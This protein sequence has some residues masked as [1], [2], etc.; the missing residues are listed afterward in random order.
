MLSIESLFLSTYLCFFLICDNETDLIWCALVSTCIWTPVNHDVLLVWTYE[1]FI[2]GTIWSI[3]HW[4]L[5]PADTR[6]WR[7]VRAA[8]LCSWWSSQ[9]TFTVH[10]AQNGE[11]IDIPA[12]RA[13]PDQTEPVF[14][15]PVRAIREI[16]GALCLVLLNR[17]LYVLHTMLHHWHFGQREGSAAKGAPSC[18]S[19]HLS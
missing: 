15:Q 17:L 3:R 2:L 12:P 1:V 14:G 11:K 4:I 9:G 7:Q 19:F 5:H 18:C 8:Y 16:P 6:Y 10:D 13:R